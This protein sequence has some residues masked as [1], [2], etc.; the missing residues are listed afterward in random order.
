[1]FAP[2]QASSLESRSS[3][4]VSLQSNPPTTGFPNYFQGP[5]L[6]KLY[7][8]TFNDESSEFM[9]LGS[10]SID[11]MDV[12]LSDNQLNTAQSNNKLQANLSNDLGMTNVV[13][14]VGRFPS[15]STAFRQALSMMID[16][17]DVVTTALAGLGNKMPDQLTPSWPSAYHVIGGYNWDIN[18]AQANTT[19]YSGGFHFNGTGNYWYNI[20][21]SSNHISPATTILY[22]RNDDGRLLYIGVQLSTMQG[23]TKS[24]YHFDRLFT[25]DP[26]TSYVTTRTVYE[27]PTSLGGYASNNCNGTGFPCFTAYTQ[28]LG[29]SSP[30][31]SWFSFTFSA[32]PSILDKPF[33]NFGHWVNTTINNLVNS[34]YLSPTRN[35]AQTREINLM[36][37][38]QAWWDPIFYY[39]DWTAMSERLTGHLT[40]Q[41]SYVPKGSFV[42]NNA[43][44]YWRVHLKGRTYGGSLRVGIYNPINSLNIFGYDS[45]RAFD[46]IILERIYD[47]LLNYNFDT[48]GFIPGLAL[49]INTTTLT[50]LNLPT[51]IDHSH[52]QPSSTPPYWTTLGG[53]RTTISTGI[54]V[55]FKLYSNRSWHDGSPITAN[56]ILWNIITDTMDPNSILQPSFAH[57]AD[58]NVTAPHTVSLWFNS[59]SWD[60]ANLAAGTP[61][62][63]P[64]PWIHAKG[65]W[66]GS[67]G[68]VSSLSVTS[69]A[70]LNLTAGA[71]NLLDGS[72]P[73]KFDPATT[74]D[75]F[76]VGSSFDLLA[77]DGWVHIDPAKASYDTGLVDLS[78][79]QYVTVGGC[80]TNSLHLTVAVVNATNSK[81]LIFANYDYQ[82]DPSI[83]SDTITGA[84]V[85]ASQYGVPTSKVNLAYNPSTRLWE[86]LLPISYTGTSYYSY[87]ITATTAHS[88]TTYGPA[89]SSQAS[90]VGISWEGDPV[91]TRFQ[92]IVNVGG[93]PTLVPGQIL[94]TTLSALSI[95]AVFIHYQRKTM[96]GR[97][98]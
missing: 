64:L 73:F 19:L 36:V 31:I 50:N 40:A 63:P 24:T 51:G 88:S 60:L 38:Q 37:T 69:K 54:R 26:V 29:F 72:G 21:N 98:E 78:P 89:G 93:C 23:A 92:F 8:T 62:A 61:M 58:A 57:L 81:G 32:D 76:T 6:A 2:L 53:S 46:H 35:D 85:T 68:R 9:A 34:W 48:A 44:S 94:L 96:V 77:N 27:A 5:R 13:F 82:P 33:Y 79:M 70:A 47:P 75:P 91:H 10:G 15:N 97:R 4:A 49:T 45:Y 87:Q 90:A 12:P 55:D 42:Y 83:I 86:G 71:M 1:M 20:A 80:G 11:A 67:D 3:S 74:G 56:D 39:Q 65:T 84:I 41:N 17:Q 25:V 22:T 7:F 28:A 30:D 52:W 59:T 14:N 95:S 16:R 66:V 43:Y 18:L